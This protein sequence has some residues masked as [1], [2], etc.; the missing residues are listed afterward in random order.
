LSGAEEG[1]RVCVK[2]VLHAA[3]TTVLRNEK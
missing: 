3:G 1:A 2:F